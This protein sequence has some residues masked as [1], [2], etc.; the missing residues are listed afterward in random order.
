[1]PPSNRIKQ[2]EGRD[3]LQSPPRDSNQPQAIGDFDEP[4][5]AAAS[6]TFPGSGL[7]IPNQLS[8]VSAPQQIFPQSS[9]PEAAAIPAAPRRAI[10]NAGR[11]S[12]AGLKRLLGVLGD[13]AGICAPLQGIVEELEGLIDVY[14]VRT[15]V[16]SPLCLADDT[17]GESELGMAMSN[18]I[19]CKISLKTCSKI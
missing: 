13:S 3:N 6:A 16:T 12:W 11:A 5:A 8:N 19:H 14:E 4:R 1:M 18:T 17:W 9:T 10:Q 7:R 2:L 15:L